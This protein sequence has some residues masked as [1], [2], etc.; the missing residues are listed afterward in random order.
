[1]RQ[2]SLSADMY[3]DM[4]LECVCMKLCIVYCEKQYFPD[5]EKRKIYLNKPM[6]EPAKARIATVE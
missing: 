2:I 6:S 1:M 5:I 3:K 4:L